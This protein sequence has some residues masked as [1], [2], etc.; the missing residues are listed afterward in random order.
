MPVIEGS[1]KKE[2]VDVPMQ[3]FL[4]TALARPVMVM[5]ATTD[6]TFDRHFRLVE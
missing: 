4:F 2:L 6:D 1:M 5:G 3:Q